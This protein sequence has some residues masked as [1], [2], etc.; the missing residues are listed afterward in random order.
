MSRPTK[1][2]V[3]KQGWGGR[4]NFQHSH[5]LKMIP[6]DIDEGNIIL[7]QILKGAVEEWESEQR[8]G[9]VYDEAEDAATADSAS[10]GSTDD[11]DDSEASCGADYA[12]SVEESSAQYDD[13]PTTET[14]QSEDAPSDDSEDM[15]D[16][17]EDHYP[18]EPYEYT[19]SDALD[20]SSSGPGD[21]AA[22]D[23]AS[24]AG[25]ADYNDDGDGS[26]SAG[27][28]GDYDDD[29]DGYDDYDDYDDSDDDD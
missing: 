15:Q 3:V 9:S 16:G 29:D 7:D 17:V 14:Q 6:D 10:D 12:S 24:D 4:P 22:S 20:Y 2:S 25:S 26:A 21:S 23:G 19:A 27:S 5:G 18:G 28:Y 8:R 13:E 11:V 1:Y